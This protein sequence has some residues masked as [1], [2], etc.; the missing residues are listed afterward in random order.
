MMII[1]EFYNKKVNFALERIYSFA[2]LSF[3]F[4]MPI[5]PEIAMKISIFSFSLL[6]FIWDYKKVYLFIKN[7]IFIKLLLLFLLLLLISYFWT[8]NYQELKRITRTFLRYWIIPTL[9]L[10]SVINK[11]NI[12]YVIPFFLLGMIVNLLISFSIY[13][14]DIKELFIFQFSQFYLVPFQS[15]HMEYSIYLALTILLLFYHFLNSNNFLTKIFISFSILG[16]MIL[17]FITEGRTGQVAFLFSTMLLA[18]IY[19]RKNMKLIFIVIVLIATSFLLAYNFSPTFK[20]RITH[21]VEDINKTDK[22]DYSTS[23]GVRLSAY[24]KIPKILESTNLFLGVGYGDSQNEVFRINRELFGQTQDQQLGRLHQSF[25]TIYQ[26]MGLL[27]LNIFI[28]MLY[29]LLKLSIR[30]NN[31]IGYSFLFCIFISLMTMDFQNQRE[32]LIL[33]ALFSSIIIMSSN[34]EQDYSNN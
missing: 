5:N 19:F 24:L 16:F 26:S 14:F 8:D 12:K 21:A 27:G 23:L 33:L 13:F 9:F 34:N 31:F 32:I 29:Y 2:I 3:S 25:L 30:N 6:L 7:N 10:I 20:N 22:N 18:I 1:R 4:F 11:F 28:F 17:L 15:S